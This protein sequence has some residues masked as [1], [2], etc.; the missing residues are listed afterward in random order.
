MLRLLR[1][2][3]ENWHAHYSLGAYSMATNEYVSQG[4]F[5]R[6]LDTCVLLASVASAPHSLTGFA[7][8]PLIFK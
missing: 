5:T 8:Y 3:N 6:G 2:H 7:D 1:L 4:E